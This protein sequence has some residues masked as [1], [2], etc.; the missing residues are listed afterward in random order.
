MSYCYITKAARFIFGEI[1]YIA[2]E[3]R[4]IVGD[5]RLYQRRG[6]LCHRGSLLCRR[7]SFYHRGGSIG[8]RRKLFL[9]GS[10]A[11]RVSLAFNRQ[12]ISFFGGVNISNKYLDWLGIETG[13]RH[14]QSCL[15]FSFHFL[16]EAKS[17]KNFFPILFSTLIYS[18][19]QE[20][21]NK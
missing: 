2:R 21:E 8:V 15:S 13:H 11:F 16:T 17:E 1:R 10:T 18:L 14:R 20:P 19:L 4:S 7:G 6:M 3:V 9:L 5:V 12:I